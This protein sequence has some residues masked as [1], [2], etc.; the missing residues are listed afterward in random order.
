MNVIAF[1]G[2]GISKASGVATFNDMPEIRE[3]LTRDFATAY[4]VEHAEILEKMRQMVRPAQPNDAHLALAEYVVP[5]CTMNIDGLHQRAGSTHV[6]EM[7]GNLEG[8]IVL[9]GDMAPGYQTAIDL[10]EE[11]A[12]LP[13]PVLLMIGTSGYTMITH[14]M[15]SLAI[16]LGYQIIKINQSAETEVRLTLEQLSRDL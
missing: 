13:H 7:H 3:R 1:T 14:S 11:K 8:E 12:R 6:I 2:A 10:V 15:E 5:V 4:P 9:Y 16:S